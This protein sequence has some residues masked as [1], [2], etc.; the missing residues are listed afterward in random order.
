MLPLMTLLM[1]SKAIGKH[2]WAA[3][4]IYILISEIRVYIPAIYVRTSSRDLNKPSDNILG[5]EQGIYDYQSNASSTYYFLAKID[6]IS[7]E[8]LDLLCVVSLHGGMKNT[9]ISL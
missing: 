7:I 9:N 5:S 6:A 4:Y 2:S 8:E 1:W 3:V